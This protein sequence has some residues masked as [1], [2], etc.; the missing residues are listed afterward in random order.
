VN[1]R[2]KNRL[3]LSLAM[4]SGTALAVALMLYA[5]SSNIDLYY[6]PREML[7]GKGAQHELPHIG[8]R[9]RVGG[10][11]MPG[12][13]KRD[14]QTLAVTFKIYDDVGAVQVSYQGILPD[15]FREG[16]GVVAQGALGEGNLLA[17][18]EV[19]AKHDDNYIPPQATTGGSPKATAR[20]SSNLLSEAAV[21]KI[22][23]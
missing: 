7:Q 14:P 2:R 3:Y 9:L 11:V 4:L 5:L 15:L 19:L 1:W 18:R 8:Q 13:V 22:A 12:S 17:A 20:L 6:T 21:G 10:L 16:Q 23:P